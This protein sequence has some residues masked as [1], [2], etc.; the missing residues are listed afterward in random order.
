[1]VGFI[2]DSA[3]QFAGNIDRARGLPERFPDSRPAGSRAP[4]RSTRCRHSAPCSTI[5]RATRRWIVIEHQLAAIVAL[6]KADTFAAAQVDG[7]PNLH[8]NRNSPS[9]RQP[10][11]RAGTLN[12]SHNSNGFKALDETTV[13]TRMKPRMG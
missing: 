9:Q 2:A 6:Q 4:S 7:R 3:A 11:R 13:Q 10:I 8:G 1:M 5:R 12:M